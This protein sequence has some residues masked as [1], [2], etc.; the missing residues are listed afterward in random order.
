MEADLTGSQLKRRQETPCQAKGSELGLS[1]YL[2]L[3]GNGG[4]GYNCNYPYSP[5]K[6]RPWA[7]ELQLWCFYSCLQGSRCKLL[8]GLERAAHAPKGSWGV[9]ITC[10]GSEVSLTVDNYSYPACTPTYPRKQE[11]SV[12]FADAPGGCQGWVVHTPRSWWCFLLLLPLILLPPLPTTTVLLP[13]RQQQGLRRH[14][15]AK[16]R[17][18]ALSSPPPQGRPDPVVPIPGH[19]GRQHYQGSA[20]VPECRAKQPTNCMNKIR[21]C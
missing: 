11:G 18:R 1:S 9:K 16:R 12:P 8:G 17:G 19:G 2:W 13:Q 6:G 14:A 21:A 3:V 10:S 7:Q 15:Q 20:T 4:M 5:I